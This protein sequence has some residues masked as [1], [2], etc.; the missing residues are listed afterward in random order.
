MNLAHRLKRASRV[1]LWHLIGS[2]VV[3]ACAA[4]LVF[5][6][7]YPHPYDEL[8]GGVNLFGLLVGADLVCGPLLT[9]VLF[10]PYKKR[11]E[12]MRDLGLVGLVQLVAL[13]YGLWTVAVAR[14]VFLVF[15]LDRFRV[16]SAA[17]IEPA[18]LANAM[19]GFQRLGFGGP[20]IIAARVARA[21]DEDFLRSVDLSLRGLGPA[22]RP[23]AWRPYASAREAVLGKAR[24]LA[25][26]ME[27]YPERA[28]DIETQSKKTGLAV[29]QIGYV[30]VQGRHELFWVALVARQDAR[31]IGFLDVDGL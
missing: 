19:D 28:K 14:P 25:L 17:E 9:L 5:G 23:S 22:L 4:T 8:S 31:V 13:V 29:D 12:L 6:L 10:S 16:V 1:A 20:K 3:A 7:W 18:D 27:R 15:E 24:P 11:A 2:A 26:L 21:G 30:P